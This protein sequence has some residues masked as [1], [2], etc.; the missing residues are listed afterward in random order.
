MAYSIML[1]AGHGGEDPGA[2][3]M[4]RQEKDDNLRLVLEVGKILKEHGVDVEYTRTTDIYQ[5]PFQKAQIANETMPDY[6]ISIHR[7]SSPMMNQY[8]GV[9]TLLY[10]LSGEKLEMAENINSALED[11]GFQNLGVKARP[12]L[13][14]LRRTK[15]PALLVEMGFINTESDN[16][17]FDEKFQEMAQAIATGILQTL[18]ME[19]VENPL[20]YRVQVG[21]YR[22]KEN[23][24]RLNNQLTMQGYP[25]FILQDGELYKVQVGAF[26]QLGNAVAMEQRLRR[27]GYPTFI[28]T[29]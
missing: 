11:V 14:V 3:S 22:Q 9:E 13:V 16:K 29:K 7:N 6:F 24:D 4:G 27:D 25:S 18:D 8:A 20:L 5:T 26:Q 10:D 17:L 23:A 19:T 15:S 28:T 2:V 21:A 1:D 12:G